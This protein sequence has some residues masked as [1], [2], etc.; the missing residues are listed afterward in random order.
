MVNKSMKN[1]L[2]SSKV[3]RVIIRIN[4]TNAETLTAEF[5]QRWRGNLDLNCTI[6]WRPATIWFEEFSDALL[7]GRMQQE[8]LR[9]NLSVEGKNDLRMLVE[10][11]RGMP[12][13]QQLAI[14]YSNSPPT[15]S[16][17]AIQYFDST[18]T[19]SISIR[20]SR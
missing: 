12:E 10:T 9:V 15:G 1:A 16:A 5:L 17:G 3:F 18:E 2:E 7:S 11:L 8:K 19:K 14:N 20:S 6:P 4:E 13:I